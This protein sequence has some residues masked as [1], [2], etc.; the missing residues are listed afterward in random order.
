M[1]T[2]RLISGEVRINFEGRIFIAFGE[3]PNAYTQIFRNGVIEAVR[4]GVLNGSQIVGVIPGLAYEET[5]VGHLP[6]CFQILKKLGCSPPVLVGIS[7]IGVR[8]LK[9]Y[10]D[11]LVALTMGDTRPIDRDV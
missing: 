11:P 9:L 10:V 2:G 1:D 3:P 8:G 4:G 7:L 5:V 6:Q